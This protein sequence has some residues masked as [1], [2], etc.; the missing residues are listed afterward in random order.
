MF[1]GFLIGYTG[2]S[3]LCLERCVTKVEDLSWEE[4][5]RWK[6]KG[7]QPRYVGVIWFC[8]CMLSNYYQL[9]LH[10]NKAC[11]ALTNIH[12]ME[13]LA[14]DGTS[15]QIESDLTLLNY[16]YWKCTFVEKKYMSP[17]NGFQ[18]SREATSL[19]TI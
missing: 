7:Y 8:F 14:Y 9:G 13:H 12:T 3:D 1:V 18:P 5:P 17:W 4:K 19:T 16:C 2:P 15:D 10:H 6:G 11:V